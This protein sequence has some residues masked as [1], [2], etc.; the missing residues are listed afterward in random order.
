[1][2]VCLQLKVFFRSKTKRNLSFQGNPNVTAKVTKRVL[3]LAR[4]QAMELYIGDF[5]RL[6]DELSMMKAS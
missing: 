2:S 5:E 4:W 3:L 6:K 1:M